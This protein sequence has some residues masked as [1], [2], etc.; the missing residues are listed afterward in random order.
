MLDLI[1]KHLN[2]PH[3]NQGCVVVKWIKQLDVKEQEAFEA[4]KKN[5][6]EIKIAQLYK[7][8]NEHGE[9]PLPFKLTAFRA[10]LRGYCTCR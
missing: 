9:K 3:E 2:A 7:D 10:H 1:N 5:N 8:L 4:V 6:H